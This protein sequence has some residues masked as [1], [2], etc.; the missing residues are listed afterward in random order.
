M[1]QYQ[2]GRGGEETPK[3]HRSQWQG[4]NDERWTNLENKMKWHKLPSKIKNKYA[5]VF[6]D[7]ENKRIGMNGIFTS[8]VLPWKC[9]TTG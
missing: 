7:V 1:L 2:W 6:V 9:K 8:I 3:G 4:P 5:R